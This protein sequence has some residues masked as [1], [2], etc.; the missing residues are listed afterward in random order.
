MNTSLL[1]KRLDARMRFA[2]SKKE[3]SPS[4]GWVR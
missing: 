3:A 2:N 4:S 1:I